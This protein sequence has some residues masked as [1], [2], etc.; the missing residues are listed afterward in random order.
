MAEIDDFSEV[1]GSYHRRTAE[2]GELFA[3]L[4]K[5]QGTFAKA[6]RVGSN[7]HFRS[8]YA[9]LDSVFEASREGC[10][11][12][13]LA[14]AQLPGNIGDNIAVTTILGHGGSGQWI[15]STF[16]MAP[17]KW[18]AQGA[19]SV[20]TYLRRYAL[21]SVLGIAPEDDDGEAAVDR[22]TTL[23][24]RPVSKAYP[25]VQPEAPP[26]Q[27][28]AKNGQEATE[29]TVEETREVVLVQTAEERARLGSLALRSWYKTV[30]QDGRR[31]LSPF[32]D[33]LKNLA[34]DAD[35][36]LRADSA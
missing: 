18:D 11:T 5:A 2:C 33:R 21:L 19:G 7:P 4:A 27:R 17:A 26:R 6:E 13:G 16:Y 9:T 35:D 23:S 1:I 15:E 8:K 36:L 32:V 20:V 29:N 31:V 25:A 3:A 34:A 12:H 10:A 24:G 14:I 30:G 22:P 28:A